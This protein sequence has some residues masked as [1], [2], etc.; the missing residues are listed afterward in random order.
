M[1]KDKNIELVGFT[2]MGEEG[3]T[4]KTLKDG[5][6]QQTLGSHVLQLMFQGL[7]GFRF[8]FA[9]FVSEQVNS[10]DLYCIVWEAVDK[11]QHH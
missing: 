3:D 10:C 11:L 9:H 8:P 4:I 5:V 1:R 2:E 7:T 6:H